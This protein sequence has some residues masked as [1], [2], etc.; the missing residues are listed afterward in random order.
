MKWLTLFAF[1]WKRRTTKSSSDVQPTTKE[2]ILSLHF[3]R[4][5][6]GCLSRRKAERVPN[7]EAHASAPD[8]PDKCPSASLILLAKA[9]RWFSDAALAGACRPRSGAPAASAA[10]RRRWLEGPAPVGAGGGSARSPSSV[11]SPLRSAP[12]HSW[13]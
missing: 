10:Q 2:S 5:P 11:R 13:P 3:H 8:K 7:L 1:T 6:A 9:R 4:V 12:L